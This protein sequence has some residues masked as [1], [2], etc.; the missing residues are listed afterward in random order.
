MKHEPNL[1]PAPQRRDTLAGDFAL[2]ADA[3]ADAFRGLSGS[4]RLE[5]RW[6]QLRYC[7][8]SF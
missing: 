3:I 5:S 2:I 1:R 8:C 7:G 4:S 6:S